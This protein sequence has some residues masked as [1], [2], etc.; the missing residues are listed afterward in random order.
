MAY[1]T[2]LITVFLGVAAAMA[3]EAEPPGLSA[4]PWSL[5]L[6][7]KYLYNSH[8]SFEFGNPFPPYQAPLSRLEFPLNSWWAGLEARRNF[9][10]FSLGLEIL[11]NLTVE[12]GDKFKDSDWDDDGRP[13]VLSLY[14]ESDCRLEPSYNIRGDMDLK[15]SDWLGLPGWLDMRPLMGIRWQQFSLVSHDGVQSYPASNDTLPSVPLPGDGIRFR[16]TYWQYFIGVRSACDLEDLTKLP[17]LKLLLQLDWAYVQG[18]NED[19]HLLREG[20]RITTETTRGGAWHSSTGL[21]FGLA[22]NINAGIEADY[23]KIQTS[24]S[25]RLVNN[26]FDIDISFDHGVNV[27]S[28]QSSLMFTLEYLF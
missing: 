27:W 9:P 5:E 8:T 7:A 12:T 10:R 16:Q 4:N 18:D 21:K 24:G 20:N 1:L 11:R 17:R 15:V 22:R 28:E 6:K 14:S 25:H 2:I 3:S 13:D 23:I 19:R 26:M